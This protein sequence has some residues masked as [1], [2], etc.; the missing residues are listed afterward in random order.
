MVMTSMLWSFV[1]GVVNDGLCRK[2]AWKKCGACF[3][4][5]TGYRLWRRLELAQVTLRSCLSGVSPAPDCAG[6]EPL[7]QLMVHVR[8]VVPEG[9]CPFAALQHRLQRALLG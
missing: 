5:S 3:S 8:A 7:A 1:A 2:A 4:C 9:G 6:V